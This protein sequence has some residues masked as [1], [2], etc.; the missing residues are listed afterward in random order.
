MLAVIVDDTGVPKDG[1]H[2]PGVKR[3]TRAASTRSDCQ[4]TVSLN[5]DGGAALPPNGAAPATHPALLDR[6]LPTC[7][8]RVNLD[9]LTL[10]HRRK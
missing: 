2:S 9:Q 8:L 10:F 5:A 3:S 4:V 6:P 7:L 1:K